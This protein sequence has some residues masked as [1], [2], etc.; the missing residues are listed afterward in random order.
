MADPIEFWF[1]FSSPFGYLG[2]QRVAEIEERT[3][4]AVRLRPYLMGAL[5]KTTGRQPLIT[6]PMVWD[7]SLHDIRR[8]ARRRGIDYSHPA[9]FPV[10]TPGACRVFY[11][12]EDTR[13]TEDAR[14]FAAAMYREYFVAGADASDPATVARV[15]ADCGFDADGAAAAIGDD[16]WKTR[17][18]EVT[19]EAGGRG[20]FGSPFCVVDGESF[21]GNDRIDDVIAWVESGG[22]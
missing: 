6:H 16:A 17:V 5:F 3:G 9:P 1:D 14:R 12:I 8:S 18:R 22:W 15:A 19:A 4:R 11:W 7:Y 10:G 20:I 21:W 13:G 2:F